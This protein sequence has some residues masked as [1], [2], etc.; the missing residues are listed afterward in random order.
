MS[1]TPPPTTPMQHD[2]CQNLAPCTRLAGGF[3]CLISMTSVQVSSVL[4]GL[5]SI[6]VHLAGPRFNL[7][8][9]LCWGAEM[10][11]ST[12][13]ARQ[14]GTRLMACMSASSAPAAP[15]PAHPTGGMRT[16]TWAPPCCYRLTGSAPLLF[17][18]SM[19]CI[20]ML[21][22]RRVLLPKWVGACCTLSVVQGHANKAFNLLGP[23]MACVYI[24]PD[25]W[26]CAV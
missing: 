3:G 4:A 21:A 13:R 18:H 24:N 20:G 19:L 9:L 22:S 15:P 26:S 16:S 6:E 25:T 12:I 14:T 5:T 10:A 11:Q 23:F 1:P 8:L 17:T 2:A 7:D